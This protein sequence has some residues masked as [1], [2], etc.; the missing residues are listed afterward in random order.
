MTQRSESLNGPWHVIVDP[1]ENG[2]YDYRRQP[3]ANGYFKNEQP[4]SK[5]DRIEYDFSRSATLDVPGD[6]NSQR[7]ELLLYE[8]CVWYQ[9]SF[10]WTP[11]AGER[12][13]LELGA[14]AQRAR[15]WLNGE[16]VR[17]HE[18]GFTG[19]GCE[20]TG[21]LRVG[22]ND[23]VIQVDNT[24]RRDSIPTV[25]TDWWNFGGLTRDVSLRVV[26]D[27]FVREVFVQ[28]ARGELARIEGF[29]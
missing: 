28:F 24:R 10:T 9:R 16:L 15:V 4:R 19:F 17:E 14:A 12:V 18:G 23:L 6:W 13:L 20:L 21:R 11:A 25:N 26:P 22:S 2:Y 8:G 5:S 7:A 27:T 3:L 29:V 1:Y